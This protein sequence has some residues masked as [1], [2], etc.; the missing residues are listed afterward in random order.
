MAQRAFLSVVIGSIIAG[1]TGII[2]KNISVPA[3]SIAFVRT[4]L[5][6]AIL[7]IWMMNRRITFFRGNYKRML[8]ASVLN[9]IRMYLFLTA[10]IYTSITQAVIMLFTW[11]I[12]VNILSSFWLKEKIS[13]KQ[14]ITLLMAFSGIVIIYG[15]QSF[16]L[17]N[18]D[19]IGM[20]AGIL[21]AL[22]YSISYIIYKTEIDNFHR[23]EIIFY[24]NLVGGFVFLPFFFF[25]NP[26]PQLNDFPLLITYGILMG[27]VIFNFFFYGLKYLKASQASMIAYVE[28]ISAVATGIIFMGDEL[29]PQILVGGLC[30]LVSIYLIRRT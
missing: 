15:N 2:I 19:F 24:Q 6:T 13:V 20:S 12:F 27:I 29:S 28:I 16:N 7:A 8:L 30:I 23:N 11:P 3:S 22:F 9:A 10:F 25:I 4:A 1:L 26:W 17:D 5:P 18:R 14:L 21:S